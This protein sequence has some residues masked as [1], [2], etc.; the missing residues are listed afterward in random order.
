MVGV[1]DTT[2]ITAAAGIAIGV[3]AA[4]EAAAWAA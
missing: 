3:E 1:E 4:A 2:M